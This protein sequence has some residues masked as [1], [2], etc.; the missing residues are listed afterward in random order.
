MKRSDGMSFRQ[1]GAAALVSLFSPVARLLPGAALKRA[2]FSGWLAPLIAL[3]F[4]LGLVWVMGRL[5][6]VEGRK[7]G[8]ADALLA[9]LGPRL[10]RAVGALLVLWLLFYGGVIL[11]SGS[12]RILSTVYPGFGLPLFLGGSLLLGMVFARG[13]LR[14]AGR[15]AFVVLLLFAGILA[16]VF[17]AALSALHWDYLWPPEVNRWQGICLGALS[18]ADVLSPWVWFSFLR[19]GVTEDEGSFPRS[20]RGVVLLCLL[21]LVFLLATIGDLGPELAL[22]QQF[23]FYVMIKNLRLLN[24]MERFDAVIVVLWMMTDYVFIGMLLLSASAGLRS[25][26]GSRRRESWVPF[27]A[28]GMLLSALLGG[29]N[30]FRF[31]WISERL[32]PVVN[33]GLAFLLLPLIALFPVKKENLQFS[34]KGVDKRGM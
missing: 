13:R 15:S 7:V 26:S 28:L 5:L 2:G 27:C 8:L 22:R 20:S 6:T 4:L 14:W 3:P 23:P 31:A 12:E 34:K 24:L 9:R 33:L 10:G 18:V 19:G 29:E 1:Y 17:A 21:T 25:L 16:V 30:A 11:R 32:I